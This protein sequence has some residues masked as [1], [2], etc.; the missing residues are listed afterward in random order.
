MDEGD[1]KPAANR[2]ME[3]R[4]H[5]EF[6]IRYDSEI[7]SLRSTVSALP[8]GIT[9]EKTTATSEPQ[10]HQEF[11][12]NWFHQMRLSHPSEAGNH[13]KQDEDAHDKSNAVWTT[14]VDEGIIQLHES[15]WR[16]AH[17]RSPLIHLTPQ[18]TSTIASVCDAIQNTQDITIGL[19]HI[20]RLRVEIKPETSTFTVTDVRR[21]LL[22]LW[23]A[24]QRI[25]TL[26]AGYC[27]PRSPAAPGLEFSR[28]FHPVSLVYPFC[29]DRNGVALT[30]FTHGPPD[31][32]KIL[33]DMHTVDIRGSLLEKK[34]IRAVGVSNDLEWL[35]EGT[36]VRLWDPDPRHDERIVTGAYDFSGLP[37]PHEKLIRFNQH[38]GTL[39]PEAIDNW[40]R[41]CCGIIDLCL[42]ATSERLECI[43]T[44][45][46]LPS[47]LDPSVRS[48]P[49]RSYTVFDLLVDLKL[50]SQA[51][52][53]KSLGPNPFVSEFV[54][55]RRWT[56]AV[57][58]EETE[59]VSP[60]TFGI[61]LE[62]LVPYSLVG[63][64]DPDPDDSRWI[65]RDPSSAAADKSA[66]QEDEEYWAARRTN[67]AIE[68][69][70]ARALDKQ[71]Y[72]ANADHL[73]S[74]LTSAGH[75][76]A[77]F[78]TL[79]DHA[80]PNDVVIPAYALHTILQ[81]A[82]NPRLYFLKRIDPRHQIWHVHRDLSL[83][84]FHLGEAGY[85]GHLGV[86]IS[87]PVLRDRPADF[88]K[89]FD[90]LK[91]LRGGVR[92]MLDPTCG[93]HVHVGN[94]RGFSLRSLK[95]IAT[96]VWVSELVLYSLV[97][98]SRESNI[99]TVPLGKGSTLACTE[100][101]SEYTAGFD[102]QNPNTKD[103]QMEAMI[104]S[105]EIEAHVPMDGIPKRIQDEILRIW[106]VSSEYGLIH[107]LQ[108][109]QVCKTGISFF[110]IR[111]SI[112]KQSGEEERKYEG[113][114]KFRMLEGTLDPEL[115]AHWT[116]LVLRI[117][118][119]GT[120]TEPFEYFCTMKKILK[121][122][123]SERE[124][125][126][127]F[128]SALGM[129]DHALFWNKVAQK[130][131][132]LSETDDGADGNQW[133]C[134][135]DKDLDLTDDEKEELMRRWC[136]RKTTRVPTVDDNSLERARSIL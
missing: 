100:D 57:N 94:I 119:R 4:I 80:V 115:I 114:V 31:K 112:E 11:L 116:K 102:L 43:K 21:T 111:S 72:T 107:L 1:H 64:R 25:D 113:T 82:R 73:V 56:P 101:L 93:F 83:S 34:K 32:V 38:A 61:E 53:Y 40:V 6:L 66:S 8:S 54:S 99:M 12:M 133:Q 35:A 105:N 36:T 123:Y 47:D 44:R 103:A 46:N 23:S 14:E 63:A 42:N 62:F 26:H 92:P 118:Q 52:Y 74:I 96:L 84:S 75:L 110:S 2:K 136:E 125:L 68:A 77:T 29:E 9:A 37:A 24:S 89:I 49:S 132:A 13:K 86:E 91:V 60:Y 55:R 15:K 81:E 90:V 70:K 124:M 30:K 79:A 95:K 106:S 76:S 3:L 120:D 33:D 59:G 117:V 98:P 65:Y 130:N 18:L 67:W 20:P 71:V 58:I 28:L 135:A 78:D 27:G 134:P 17:V 131:K 109:D 22:F 129:E 121:E 69:I 45:L 5:L 108:P 19:N 39:D 88:E 16:L 48:S 85:A 128:L 7:S 51:A 122:Y 50:P 87:S 126:E 10:G 104:L 97:H 41:V 127:G